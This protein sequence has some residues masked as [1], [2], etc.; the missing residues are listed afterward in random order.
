MPSKTI[1]VTLRFPVDHYIGTLPPGTRAYIVRQL[2]DRA[3]GESELQER[4]REV[5]RKLDLV[6]SILQENAF[7]KEKSSPAVNIDPDDFLSFL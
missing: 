2:V 4:L 5:E 7:P 3:L 1:R 6:L